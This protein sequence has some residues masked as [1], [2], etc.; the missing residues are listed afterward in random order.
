MEK[1]VNK[2][3]SKKKLVTQA[4]FMEIIEEKWNNIDQT[5]CFNL[6]NSMKKRIELIIQRNGN[7]IQY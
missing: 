7:I 1:K 3:I 4:I 6:A 2:L 5:L